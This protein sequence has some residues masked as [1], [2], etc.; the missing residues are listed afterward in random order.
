[1]VKVIGTNLHQYM[2]NVPV[3]S[4]NPF[5][6]N[7]YRNGEWT[8]NDNR[9]VMQEAYGAFAYD[10]A[11]EDID[12][13]VVAVKAGFK[14]QIAL[15]SS[16]I[17]R[18]NGIELPTGFE[19]EAIGIGGNQFLRFT[20]TAG[21]F[22]EISGGITNDIMEDWSRLEGQLDND[23]VNRILQEQTNPNENE[24]QRVRFS[25]DGNTIFSYESIKGS[26]VTGN[27][28]AV[29]LDGVEKLPEEEEGGVPQEQ[30]ELVPEGETA[31]T[32]DDIGTWE[33]IHD[34]YGHQWEVVELNSPTENKTWAFYFDGVLQSAFADKND[35][36]IALNFHYE[37]TVKYIL[38]TSPTVNYDGG[39]TLFY[40][41]GLVFATR[42]LGVFL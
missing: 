35:A 36:L 3:E 14:V 10:E 4:E 21:G 1:M 32:K 19:R 41:I 30:T 42:M 2:D 33:L 38:A 17:S 25:A 24:Y 40:M 34:E 39:T 13:F 12:Y 22:I 23:E 8:E 29:I 26:W 15:E 6:I 9:F 31:V 11:P 37:N 27:V 5:Y 16:S 28:M 18:W 20:M 7:H